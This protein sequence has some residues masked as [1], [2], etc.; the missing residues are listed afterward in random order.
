[1]A[2][3]DNRVIPAYHQD[4]CINCCGHGKAELPSFYIADVCWFHS[5]DIEFYNVGLCY[6]YNAF[7]KTLVKIYYYSIYHPGY[8]TNDYLDKKRIKKFAENK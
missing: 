8:N 4:I 1:M 2:C 6:R 7:F 3:A 5:L